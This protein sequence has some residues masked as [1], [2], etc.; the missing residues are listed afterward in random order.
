[1][2]VF[3]EKHLDTEMYSA[4]RDQMP[5]WPDLF[6]IIDVP[7]DLPIAVVELL[8]NKTTFVCNQLDSDAPPIFNFTDL[9]EEAWAY[10]VK[11]EIT[12][13]H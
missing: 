10:A 8:A 3:L 2:N 4:V 5:A 11:G 7:D 6:L 12:S 9:G 13:T 1:M